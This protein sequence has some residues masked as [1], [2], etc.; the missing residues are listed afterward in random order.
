MKPLLCIVI[1]ALFFSC[2]REEKTHVP[3]KILKASLEYQINSKLGE[4]AFWNHKTNELYWIDILDNKLHLY[5]PKTQTNKYLD[6]PSSIGTVVPSDKEFEAIVALQDGIFVIDTQ[7]GYLELFSGVERDITGNRFNDGK[8]DP[9]GRFWVGSMAF[10]Q[11]QYRA[12]LYMVNSQGEA[13]IKKDSVTISN[14][15]VWSNDKTT[16][17]YIDTPTAEIKAYDYDDA[18]GNISNER[19]AVKVNDSLGYPDGMAI[20][21]NDNLWVGMWNGNAVIQFDPK[22]GDIISKVEVPAHNVTSCAFGGDNLNVL[23][24]TTANIDMTEEERQQFS[25]AG[26]IFKIKT[27]VKGVK[28]SFFKSE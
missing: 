18:T 26:S 4:G 25:L 5:N 21:E 11:K 6:T 1:I 23:Y 14:G 3:I 15:I 8:C 28:S 12:K 19:V 22:T 2:K 20:D 10:S 9:S 27:E 24:I 13:L 17:Y 16:M 7:N